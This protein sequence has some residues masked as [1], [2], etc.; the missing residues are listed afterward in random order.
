MPAP[1]HLAWLAAAGAFGGAH[2]PAGVKWLAD[3]VG[4]VG[5]ATR[6]PLLPLGE[7]GRRAGQVSACACAPFDV[8]KPA[9]GM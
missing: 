3:G 2:G 1:E 9:C 8:W 7:E 4:L 6:R 5:G